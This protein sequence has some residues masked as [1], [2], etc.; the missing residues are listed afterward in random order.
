MF[1]ILQLNL[2]TLRAVEMDTF[3]DEKVAEKVKTM[4][5][6]NTESMLKENWPKKFK[7]NISQLRYVICKK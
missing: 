7:E 4:Y 6:K 1:I 3:D 5:E 2:K